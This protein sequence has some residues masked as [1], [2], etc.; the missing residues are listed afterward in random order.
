MTGSSQSTAGLGGS[1]DPMNAGRDHAASF[2]GTAEYLVSLNHYCEGV[3]CA[4]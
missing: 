2:V 4:V 3:L 1:T